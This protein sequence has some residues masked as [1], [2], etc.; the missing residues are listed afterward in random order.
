MSRE[1]SALI[2]K[3]GRQGPR[4]TS[5]PASPY[6]RDE[7]GESHYRDRLAEAAASR[8]P[9]ALYVH[10]PFCEERCHFCGCSVV[11]D[12]HKS[13][14]SA[15]LDW[16]G[17]EMAMVREALG[18]RSSLI[19]LHWGGGTP[20][21]LSDQETDRLFALVTRH[22]SLESE[23]EVA[24]EVDP[25]V[26]SV[27]R[28]RQLRA[29]GFNRISL[30]VQDLDPSVQEAIGRNQT[31]EQTT[32][33]LE[34]SRDLGFS[35]INVDLIYG[36]PHQT[37]ELFE[38][39]ARRVAELRPD[40]LA[41]YQYAHVPWIRPQQKAIDEGDLPKPEDKLEIFRRAEDVF[42]EAGYRAIGMDHFALAGD[43]LCR[44]QDQGRLHRNF[45]GY[46]V[47]PATDQIG[48]G[49]TAIGDVADAYIQNE[50][51]LSRYRDALVG[52]HLPVER[53]LHLSEDDRRRR[54]VIQ[55]LLCNF[56]LSDAALK[57]RFGVDLENGFGEELEALRPLM[58]DGL[59][60]RV[61]DGL[62]VTDV[63]RHFVRNIAMVFD[64]Y[65]RESREQPRFSRTH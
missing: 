61:D 58:D 21:H 5:Y 60:E 42:G 25:R 64:R 63:G 1:L 49:L 50:K 7:L 39:T 33:L 36:L 44:A 28:L 54:Y 16:L 32:T 18:S 47:R 55:Q 9:L 23:A 48:L 10:V 53:G 11:I 6:F 27:D 12:K 8:E 29:L 13:L 56:R 17:L 51:K 37:P 31:E 65:L 52:G 59:V 38:R 14:A 41:V 43:E 20:T 4:Y 3:Y 46:T 22:F 19:Q 34:A 15:Y 30:G 24:I 62:K 45:M 26:T 2:E 35:S 57:E 40:R